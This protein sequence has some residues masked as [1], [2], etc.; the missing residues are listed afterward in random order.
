MEIGDTVKNKSLFAVLGID[1]SNGGNNVF[2]H[3]LIMS[4]SSLR[5]DMPI[6]LQLPDSRLLKHSM[7]NYCQ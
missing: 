4:L 3:I 5:V 1:K 2:C 6:T 7:V